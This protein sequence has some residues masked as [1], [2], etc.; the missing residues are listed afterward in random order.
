MRFLILPLF[1]G[2]VLAA[3]FA[4]FSVEPFGTQI[5]NLDTGVTTLPQGGILTDNENGLRLRAGYIEYKEGMFIRARALELLSQKESFQ[6]QALEHDIPRQE[7]RYTRLSFS[8]PDFK[9]LQAERA[10]ALLEEGILVGKGILSEK[11]A[12]KAELLVVDLKRR[13]ALVGGNF[14]L[15]EGQRVLTGTGPSARLLIQFSF[16]RLKADTRVPQGHR[17]LR[18][19]VP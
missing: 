7:A 1:W 6:A 11:P 14:S 17:L 3:R 12:L 8:N 18:Y 4:A 2:L 16:G 5:L 19:A 9:N 10:L 13:E 15:R